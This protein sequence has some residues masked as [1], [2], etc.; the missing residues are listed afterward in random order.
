MRKEEGK[1]KVE[2]VRRKRGKGLRKEE[3]KR[4]MEE[5]VRRKRGKG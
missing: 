4:R 2:E 1:R 5:E 3:G